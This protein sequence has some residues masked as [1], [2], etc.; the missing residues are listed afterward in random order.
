MAAILTLAHRECCR[1]N[2]LLRRTNSDPRQTFVKSSKR[3]S[4]PP[5]DHPTMQ[6]RTTYEFWLA[7]SRFERFAAYAVVSGNP[8]GG[9]LD[10][11]RLSRQ[12]REAETDAQVNVAGHK[13]DVCVQT[14]TMSKRASSR[15]RTSHGLPCIR[16]VLANSRCS[17]CGPE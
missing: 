5:V 9:G 14:F 15:W 13:H 1:A 3:L 10:T 6:I 2:G 11:W 17:R 4:M 16:S 12:M 7:L 8:I